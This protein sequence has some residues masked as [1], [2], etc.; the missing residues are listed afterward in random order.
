MRHYKN[1]P[2]YKKTLVIVEI[3]KR[4]FFVLFLRSCSNTRQQSFEHGRV[5]L[6]LKQKIS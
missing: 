4:D 6:Y 5:D 1:I 2:V 3:R